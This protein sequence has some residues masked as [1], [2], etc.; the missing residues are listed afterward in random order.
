MKKKHEKSHY[1]RLKKYLPRG[2]RKIIFENTGASE[3]L[4]DHVL[5]GLREDN[6]G[7][8]TEAY[9]LA[10]EEQ[11]KKNSNSIKLDLLQKELNN[12]KA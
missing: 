5:R 7:I 9:R 3:S 1:Q 11:K 2:Y 4:I 12:S 10:V 8:L 6:K